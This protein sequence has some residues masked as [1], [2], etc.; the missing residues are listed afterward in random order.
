M[1][2]SSK[3]GNGFTRTPNHL[4]RTQTRATEKVLLS[5]KYLAPDI[6]RDQTMKKLLPIEQRLY[7]KMNNVSIHP[8][9]RSRGVGSVVSHPL[10]DDIFAD[11]TIFGSYVVANECVCAVEFVWSEVDSIVQLAYMRRSSISCL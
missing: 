5:L 3:I 8:V 6:C 10:I 4:I 9:F 2:S 11:G 1:Y 7:G